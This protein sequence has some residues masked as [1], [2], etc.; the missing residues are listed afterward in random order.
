VR[1]PV[2]LNDCRRVLEQQRAGETAGGEERPAGAEDDWDEVDN[3][4]VDRTELER[5]AANLAAGDVDVTVAGELS[6]GGDRRLHV[7]DERERRC[8]GVLPVRRRPVGD[9][10]DVLAY[11]WLC[12]SSRWSDR[13]PAVR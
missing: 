8:A 11:C 9:D 13:R 5:L 10:E 12:R 3:D 4:L 6:G 7:I 1:D 2:A